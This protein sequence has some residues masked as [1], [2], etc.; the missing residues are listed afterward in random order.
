MTEASNPANPKH[1]PSTQVPVRRRRSRLAAIVAA[2]SA[3]VLVLV[4][5]AGGWYFAGRIHAEALDAEARRAGLERQYDLEIEGVSDVSLTLND[6]GGG[7]RHS[8]VWG[9]AW[10]GGYGLVGEITSASETTVTRWFQLVDG[11]IPVPGERVDVHERAFP[12]EP[13]AVLGESP[14][15]VVV[16]GPLGDY[17]SWFYPGERSTWALLLHGN[18]LD[19]LDLGKLMPAI[20]GAGFP[21][22]IVTIRNDP[23]AP[24]DPSGMLR[25]G[26]TE[27]ADLEAAVRYATG[28]GADGVELIAPSMGG[29]VA[30]TFLERSESAGVVRAVVLDSPLIDFGRTID[31]RAADEGLPLLGLPLPG[32]LVGTAKWL[33]AKRFG[34]DWDATGHLD[35]TDELAVPI[36]IFHGTDDDDV[37]IETSRELAAARPDLV[38]LVEV[39]GAPHLA[40]WNLDPAA[41]EADLLAFLE[42]ATR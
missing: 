30:L 34:V 25:Y 9:V 32:T 12:D 7:A 22:L 29:G 20:R 41:Y 33:T 3:L 18:G 24:E 4:H 6:P 28:H 2:S 42:S 5:L 15:V 39:D 23:G 35:Q 13:A 1:E 19:R 16:E 11:S 31:A 37:P 26:D 21:V 10:P 40:S 38:T 14:E 8:G 27:W 17:E 36:L